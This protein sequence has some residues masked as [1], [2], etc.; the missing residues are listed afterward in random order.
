MLKNYFLVGLRNILRSP[1]FSAINIIGLVLGITCSTILFVYAWREVTRDHYHTKA[2][3]L[4]RITLQQR[5]KDE[6]GA[7]TPGPLAPELKANFPEI[8]NTAR[9]GKWSG[10]FKTKDVLFSESNVF[11]ADN[12]LLHMFDFP[13][14]AGDLKTALTQPKHLLL[15]E[16][17][18]AKYFGNEWRVRNDIIGTTFRLN[19]ETDFV[20]V[21]IFKDQPAESS[22]QF[23]FLLSFEH[24]VTD[25]WSYNWGSHNFNTFVELAPGHSIEDFNNKIREVLIKR[26]PQAGFSLSTQPIK[27][28]YLHPLAYDYWTQQG[29]F[30]YVKIYTIIG[31]GILLI[32][33]F[34]FIN[35]ATA[36]SGKRSKEVGIRKTI[37]ATAI[38]IFGQFVGESIVVVILA[39]LISRALIDLLL[40]YFSY[41][42]GTEISLSSSNY[43]FSLALIAF[44]LLIGFL[45]SVYPATRMATVNP[46]KSFKG[47]VNAGSGKTFRETLVVAQFCMS[48]L[49][50]VSAVVIYKQVKFVQTKALGFDKEQVM[51]VG[52]N[53]S[54]REKSATF[55][56]ELLKQTE[57]EKA[58]ASTSIFVNNENLSNIEWEG[59]LPGQQINITQ[60]NANPHVIPLMGM[61]M[62]YGRNFSEDI[63][64]DTIG[65]II[66]ET[67]SRQMGFQQGEAVGKRVVFWGLPGT[68]IGIVKDFNFRPLSVGIEPFIMRYRP[69]EFYFNMLIKVKPNQVAALIE[70]LPKIYKQ[71]DAENPV[72]FGF[73]NERLNRQYQTEERALS[74]VFHFCV[75][76]ILI[77]C[78]GLFGLATFIAEQRTKEIGI[79]KVLGGSVLNIVTMLSK[80]FVRPMLVAVVLATPIGWFLLQKWLNGYVH[81]TELS[82]WIFVGTAAL[83]IAIAWLTVSSRAIQAAMVNPVESL[84]SE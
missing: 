7:V 43:L 34:N 70:K 69:K 27:D 83:S 57:V 8:I 18:A 41:V 29:N 28:M 25:R 67:A 65:Y 32:A 53:G 59:Q 21:G 12:A 80:D 31:I 35:L 16:S 37:G 77:T 63:K 20:A 47:L 84:R 62:V 26:D 14:V 42:I 82:W 33:C 74:I 17:M 23:D 5:D 44:T 15:S 68:I 2:N 52:L 55:R 4:Y 51:F 1:L 24:L 45:A 64:S 11:F 61:K 46:V 48:F 81:R 60:M 9:L 10:V 22:L 76:S 30:T 78:L 72:T 66:N 3:S 6:V 71:F 19:N 13:L 79:R 49:L 73:V 36:Q 40:P 75:L 54:L 38:Q 56:E 39:A 50:L 58:A